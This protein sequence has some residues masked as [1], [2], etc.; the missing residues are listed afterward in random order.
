MGA[1]FILGKEQGVEPTTALRIFAAQ[2]GPNSDNQT[3]ILASAIEVEP[4]TGLR[5]FA[6]IHCP[7]SIAKFMEVE[8]TT[9]LRIFASVENCAGGCGQ[10]IVTAS[11][12]DLQGPFISASYYIAPNPA[13][14][15]GNSPFVG[16]F[17]GQQCPPN[18]SCDCAQD[19]ANF[20]TPV[21]V[22]PL[23]NGFTVI[24]SGQTGTDVWSFDPNSTFV[25]MPPPTL[26]S[27]NALGG[28]NALV[29]N[30]F[31]C[32]G[33]QQITWN[34]AVTAGQLVIQQTF[35]AGNIYLRVCDGGALTGAPFQNSST[36]YFNVP[37]PFI[38]YPPP[39]IANTKCCDGVYSADDQGNPIAVN[40]TGYLVLTIQYFD[41]QGPKCP[42]N[43]SIL[44]CSEFP[45]VEASSLIGTVYVL[46]WGPISLTSGNVLT[47]VRTYQNLTLSYNPT[48]QQYE[49]PLPIDLSDPTCHRFDPFTGQANCTPNDPYCTGDP[50]GSDLWFLQIDRR[51]CQPVFA[52]HCDAQDSSAIPIQ[53]CGGWIDSF[54]DCCGPP[55]IGSGFMGSLFFD[56]QFC[57]PPPPIPLSNGEGVPL[58]Y[59]TGL[60]LVGQCSP[61]LSQQ[62]FARYFSQPYGNTSWI[63]V[64]ISE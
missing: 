63:Y 3:P 20:Y 28:G 34:F 9:A 23:C 5:I 24:G 52:P 47:L 26:P 55:L 18:P 33:E 43:P 10:F 49:C 35:A 42:I 31:T 4:T 57:G 62:W 8:P 38:Q 59:T 36:F 2:A 51:V 29:A 14:P 41:G 46:S 21:C 16:C 25:P 37:D 22:T 56:P 13:D 48:Y 53:S 58:S 40:G 27:C 15:F 1:D 50:P 7:M 60:P 45:F 32:G 54:C 19:P 12:G 6:G 64:E 11:T 44:C 30:F 17:L 61:F 39:D